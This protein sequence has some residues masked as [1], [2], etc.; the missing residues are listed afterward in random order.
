MWYSYIT[1]ERLKFEKVYV[2]ASGC[3][4]YEAEGTGKETT[5]NG[6]YC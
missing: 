2:S 5:G 6:K 1:G 4:R 3:S